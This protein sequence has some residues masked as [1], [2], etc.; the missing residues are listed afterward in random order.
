VEWTEYRVPLFDERDHSDFDV[1]VPVA[2]AV[3]LLGLPCAPTRHGRR[4][5]LQHSLPVRYVWVAGFTREFEQRPAA[6]RTSW[7]T[8]SSTRLGRDLRAVIRYPTPAFAVSSA[9]T[10]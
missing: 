7:A 4:R 2:R 10:Y 3:T 1:Q 9:A 5:L 8:P 6:R